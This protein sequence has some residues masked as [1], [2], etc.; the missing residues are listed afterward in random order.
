MSQIN[1][2]K[3]TWIEDLFTTRSKNILSFLPWRCLNST[4]GKI[5]TTS[6]PTDPQIN[7]AIAEIVANVGCAT[8]EQGIV[9]IPTNNI[10]WGN[11]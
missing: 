3:I 11:W 10:H 9:L 4:E 1:N 8:K 6:I 7:Q 2:Y 5:I